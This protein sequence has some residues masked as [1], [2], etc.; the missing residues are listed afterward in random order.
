[1]QPC[2]IGAEAPDEGPVRERRKIA[3]RREAEQVEAL[4]RIGIEVE[5]S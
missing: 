2:S 3:E 1:M 5:E 4:E